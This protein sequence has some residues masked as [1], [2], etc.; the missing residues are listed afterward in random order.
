MEMWTLDC[1]LFQVVYCR[2]RSGS[3]PKLLPRKAFNIYSIL[4]ARLTPCFC[5]GG[6][7]LFK[8]LCFSQ[9]VFW[10]SLFLCLHHQATGVLSTPCQCCQFSHNYLIISHKPLWLLRWLMHLKIKF[11]V[12][13]QTTGLDRIQLQTQLLWQDEGARKML[14][15]KIQKTSSELTQG[16]SQMQKEDATADNLAASQRL[17][18]W[19][20]WTAPWPF[21]RLLL[22]Y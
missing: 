5:C 8:C 20:V 6:H 3:V 16:A 9:T 12:I 4:G 22:I 13:S 7:L 21:P 17:Q 18:L 15:I 14:L 10:S 1:N 11:P 2:W 19:F